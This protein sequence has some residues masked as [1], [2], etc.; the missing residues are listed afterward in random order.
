MSGGIVPAKKTE[1]FHLLIPVPWS[2]IQCLTICFGGPY[3]SRFNCL[4]FLLH[5]LLER[6]L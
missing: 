4:Y 3:L 5:Q 6:V 2:A 1:S